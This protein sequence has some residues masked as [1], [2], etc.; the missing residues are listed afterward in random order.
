[1]LDLSL[2]GNWG[3]TMLAQSSLCL[4]HTQPHSSLLPSPLVFI[5]LLQGLQNT[6]QSCS[7]GAKSDTLCRL[8]DVRFQDCGTRLPICPAQDGMLLHFWQ[9]N[10]IRTPPPIKSAVKCWAF[11]LPVN[12]APVGKVCITPRFSVPLLISEGN[13]S[14]KLMMM[15]KQSYLKEL[16]QRTKCHFENFE[17]TDQTDGK[18]IHILSCSPKL[19]HNFSEA[20]T[21]Q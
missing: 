8:R 14:L 9:M 16:K 4:M 17:Y 1:M 12:S 10:T 3:F 18:I 13:H 2:L 19:I 21:C 15:M 5:Q 11:L 7:M 20:I 6:Y